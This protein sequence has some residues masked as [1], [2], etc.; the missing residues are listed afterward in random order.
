MLP[1]HAYGFFKFKIL[2]IT[3]SGRLESLTVCRFQRVAL[4]PQLF[5]GVISQG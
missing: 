5:E 2:L 4:S 3:Y 1:P